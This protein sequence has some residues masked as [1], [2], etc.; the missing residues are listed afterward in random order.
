MQENA[1]GSGARSRRDFRRALLLLTTAIPQAVRRIELKHS[2]A[3]LAL[4]LLAVVLVVL[5]TRGSIAA[6]NVPR[7]PC[8]VPL[9]IELTPD[10]PTLAT[11]D[12]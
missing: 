9:S 8:V 10:V 12:S 5:V 6:A 2:K 1:G 11:R 4:P 3:T 7:R